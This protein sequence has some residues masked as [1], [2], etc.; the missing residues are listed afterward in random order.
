MEVSQE[1]TRRTAVRVHAE[2]RFG[3]VLL[4]LLATFVFMAA[5]PTGDWSRLVT[6]LLQGATLIAALLAAAVPR[7]LVHLAVL[8]TV[9][10]FIAIAVTALISGTDLGGIVAVLDALLVATA[11]TAIVW[12][13]LRRRVIDVRTVLGALCIY[14]L[15]GMFWAFVFSAIGAFGSDPFFVQES[16]PTSADYLYFAFVTLTTVGYG[17]LTAAG[18]FGR[19][20]AVLDAL[21]GQIY[22]VTVVALLVS[23]MGRRGLARAPEGAEG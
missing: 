8:A 6:L 3:L 15:L 20:L 2:Y 22:L 11:A 4:L 16:N 5:S 21:F 17:D 14:V 10:A 23:N 13:I 18:G 7:R 12:S 9:V 19:A 1:T